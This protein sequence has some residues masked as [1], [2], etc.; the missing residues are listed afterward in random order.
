MAFSGVTRWEGEAKILL[1]IPK[2]AGVSAR[3]KSLVNRSAA[4]KLNHL[5]LSSSY[6]RSPIT[7]ARYSVSDESTCL[8][9]PLGE[10]TSEGYKTRQ[11][12]HHILA[13]PIQMIVSRRK[14]VN[15]REYLCE[16]YSKFAINLREKESPRYY[17]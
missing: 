10:G 8:I 1:P 7:A 14:S 15:N 6:D 13:V 2:F 11:T 9:G 5:M 17:L 12:I 16:R 4:L 3:R